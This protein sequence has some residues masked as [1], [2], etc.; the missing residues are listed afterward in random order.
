V[1]YG[2]PFYFPPF[3]KQGESFI[4]SFIN[5]TKKSDEILIEKFKTSEGFNLF[6]YPFAGRLVH[7]GL[8]ILTAYRL[9]LIKKNSF[10]IQLFIIFVKSNNVISL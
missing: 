1:F 10:S 7:E 2:I 8:S 5:L 3:S 6:F 4:E 9:T